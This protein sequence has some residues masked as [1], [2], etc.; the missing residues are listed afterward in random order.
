MM[1]ISGPLIGFVCQNDKEA[2]L[3]YRVANDF[4]LKKGFSVYR[5]DV[6][7]PL[8]LLQAYAHGLFNLPRC[9]DPMEPAAF[10]TDEQFQEAIVNL[11][12]LNLGP[13]LKER[14]H[15]MTESYWVRPVALITTDARNKTFHSMK[16]IGYK[17]IRIE[18][19]K[20]EDRLHRKEANFVEEDCL[21]K[22]EDFQKN[23]KESVAKALKA[24]LRKFQA[25][26]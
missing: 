24:I 1:V 18:A 4:L 21:V 5:V 3:C 2:S 15:Q 14:I 8:R 13:A 19:G 17:F 26:A 7:Y 25:R 6:L 20:S 23:P 10:E 12:E 11:Y 16:R 22:R 9:G